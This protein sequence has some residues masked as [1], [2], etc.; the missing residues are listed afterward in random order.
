M[1]PVFFIGF[2][3]HY[4]GRHPPATAH[5]NTHTKMQ[6]KRREIGSSRMSRESEGRGEGEGAVHKGEAWIKS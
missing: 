1:L 3:H 4:E 5:T 6:G 2:H